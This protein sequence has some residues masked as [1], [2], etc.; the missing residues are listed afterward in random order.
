MTTRRGG[1]PAR[2]EGS[3]R[4]PS[5]YVYIDGDHV[6]RT[7]NPSAAA[8]F[9]AVIESGILKDLSDKGL[10]ISTVVEPSSPQRLQSFASPRGEIPVRLLRHPRISFISYPYEWTFDQLQDA[11]LAHLDLQIAALDRGFVLTDASPYNM[12]VHAGRF[13]HIDPL[14]LRAYRENEPWTA[15]N[16]FCRQFLLPLLVEAWRGLPFQQLLRGRVEGIS[17]ADALTI[18]PK[19]KLYTSLNGFMHVGLQARMIAKASS[20]DQAKSAKVPSLPK[21]R[22]RAL[23]T[24][25]RVWIVGL[26][27]GRPHATFW[28]Q[29]ATENSYSS[30][31]KQVKE[32]FIADWAADRVKGGTIWDVGGNTGDYSI[33]ALKAGASAAVIFDAD[34]DS[35]EK[36]HARSKTDWPGLLPLLMDIADPSPGMGWRQRER[37]GLDGRSRPDGIMALAVIHHLAIG[38]N[39][40][41]EEIV[42]WFVDTAPRGIIEFVPKTDSM[43]SEMLLLRDDVFID[44]DEAHFR[45]YLGRRAR[46]T[47]EHRFEENNRLIVSYER[48]A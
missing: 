1:A 3:F 12:Q 31:M 37:K 25:L 9:D 40:P 19:G 44:Y 47:R 48:L 28:N 30:H 46:I 7:I 10:L 6:F 26:K 17:F 13:I 2:D 43:V 14:S 16:Q 5:G 21:S 8:T 36:A 41:L 35:L 32:S 20:S 15:Y 22:Y 4:D 29:Y 34:I 42:D 33:A 39:L 11:A 38:R 23:L 45:D 18:L 27:S 24:E